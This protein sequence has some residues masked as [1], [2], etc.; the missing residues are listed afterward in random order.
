MTRPYSDDSVETMRL[1]LRGTISTLKA[2]RA[3]MPAQW[4][5]LTDYEKKLASR[6]SMTIDNLIGLHDSLPTLLQDWPSYSA[7][8]ERQEETPVEE[9]I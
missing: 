4:G 2:L 3:A 1:T 8:T 5:D 6:F 7:F 9:A